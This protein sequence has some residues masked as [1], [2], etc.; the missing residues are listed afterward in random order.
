MTDPAASMALPMDDDFRVLLHNE[1]HARPSAR[2]HLPTLITHIAVLNGGVNQEQELAYLR[3]LPQQDGLQLKDLASHF[4]SLP[5]PGG[6]LKWERHTEFTGYTLIERLDAQPTPISA[7]STF[8]SELTV[9]KAWLPSVPGR[10]VCAVRLIMLGAESFELEDW[11]E[12]GQRWFGDQPVVAS[13]VGNPSQQGSALLGHSVAMTGFNLEADGFEQILLV[14]Q[15]PMSPTRA[16]R[17]AQR[18]LELETYRMMALRGLPVARSLGGILTLAETE[19]AG[20]TQQLEHKSTSDAAL[21]AQLVSLAATVERV[22]AENDYRFSATLA[23]H[24]LVTQRIQELREKPVPGIQTIGEFMR[25]R[26]SPAIATVEATRQ[27]LKSLS[28]RVARASSLLSTRVNIATEEQN[29]QLLE[30]LTRGQALQLR[31]QTT[32]EGLSLAAISYYVVSLVLYAGK[33]IKATGLPID[34]EI[35]AGASIPLIL[36]AVWKV[37]SRVHANLRVDQTSYRP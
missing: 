33:A 7:Q 31:L 27:R 2:I 19:L 1:V 15:T 18:L 23:Y 25:R 22:T 13:W 4:L 12:R 32:V 9:A 35:L 28:E 11:V 37:I 26:L 16:G 6:V 30:K 20:I 8:S 34:P 14:G 17:I 3:R 29:Q 5:I 36:V 24:A 21:L 10:T